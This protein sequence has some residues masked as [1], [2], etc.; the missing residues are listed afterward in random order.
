MRIVIDGGC[1]SG[2]TTF[3]K[4]KGFGNDICNLSINNL[5]FPI[6]SDLLDTSFNEGLNCGILPPKS[7]QDWNSLFYFILQN[8]KKQYDFAKGSEDKI[9]WYDR[10]VPYIHVIAKEESVP[11]DLEVIN[12]IREFQYDYVFVFS[13][14]ETFDLSHT[15]KGGF[16]FFSLED[17]YNSFEN[18]YEAY[19]NYLKNV[20]KV[21]VFSDNLVDN[22]KKRYDFI[23]RIINN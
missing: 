23:N 3:L 13:P 9:F 22:F 19:S 4:G 11:M 20:Y 15:A 16:K 12:R 5:G 17:R 14:I 1:G 7:D 21:P 2:K 18:T 8:G 6:L 10:G